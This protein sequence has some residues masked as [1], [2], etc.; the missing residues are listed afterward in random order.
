MPTLQATDCFDYFKCKSMKEA[1]IQLIL[2]R[3]IQQGKFF[4]HIRNVDSVNKL[5]ESLHDEDSFPSFSIDY[6]SRKRLISAAKY[7]ISSLE[8]VRVISTASKNISINKKDK[9]FPDLLLINQEENKLI[10]L[11]IKRSIKTTRETLTEMLAYDHEIRNSLPFLSNFEIL[12]CVVSTEYSTL[13]KHSI[14]GLVTWESKQ[15][16]CLHVEEA[17]EDLEIEVY[18]PPAWTSLHINDLPSKAISTLNLILYKRADNELS[19][20]AESAAFYAASLIAKD[21]DRNNSH[22][23]VLIWRDCWN[24]EDLAGAGEYHLT[25]GFIN[26][27]VFLPFSQSL[28]IVDFSESPL[29]QYLLENADNF[30]SYYC[31][32]VIEKGLKF[33]EKFFHVYI[34][35]LSTWNDDRSK[36][37]EVSNPIALMCHRALPLR[38]D[39]WGTLGDF[40]RD[41]IIHPG[42]EKFL[43]SK[44][45][46]KVLGCEDPFIGI[47]LIDNISGARKV[48]ERGFTCRTLFDLGVS[49]GSILSLYNTAIQQEKSDLKNL[50]ASLTWCMLDIQSAVLE[51]GSQYSSSN[52]LNIPPPVVKFRSENGFEEAFESIQQLI[53]WIHAEFLGRTRNIHSEC[54]MV[55]CTVHPLMDE[56]FACSISEMEKS[57]IIE[58]VVTSSVSLLKWIA[59][60]C[61][62]D[63]ISLECVENTLSVIASEYLDDTQSISRNSVLS[64][65][66]GITHETHF[67]LYES[68]LMNLLDQLILPINYKSDVS[69]NLSEYNHLDWIWIREEILDLRE[70]GVEFPALKVNL[71]GEVGIVDISKEVYA[72]VLNIDFENQFVFITCSNEMEMMLIRSWDEVI[73]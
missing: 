62:S 72:S 3:L 7:V 35:G 49:L 32:E 34:E 48:D 16:L 71:I 53:D 29:G 20:N 30:H 18:I 21:G 24:A 57:L 10:I 58:R 60:Q 73:S 5:Y 37:R 13:L 36:P 63:K 27:Y 25:I 68:T 59:N 22:G 42:V 1:Q 19:Q 70:H 23:F 64:V 39:L 4:S 47:P 26:P 6:L 56:Y 43:L 61:L 17:E 45:S 14:T 67:R 50:P 38:V 28:G 11:E 44:F 65:I 55:G 51:L 33:L 12:F 40:A 9:L 31:K 46:G 15:I 41:L 52:E 54:F 8:S 2:E 69:Q 66:D